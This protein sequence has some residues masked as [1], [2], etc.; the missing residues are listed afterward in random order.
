[1][2]QFVPVSTEIGTLSGRDAI[3][4]TSV[5]F[6]DRCNTVEVSGEFNC[7]LA[8]KPLAATGKWQAYTIRFCNVLALRVTELAA[9]ESTQGGKW[10]KTSFDEVIESEWLAQLRSSENPELHH[11][12]LQTYDDVFEVICAGYELDMKGT[13]D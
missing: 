1:M 6:P 11:F 2:S 8:S 12:I 13:H 4:L 5:S 7:A 3:Y 10:P 9:W